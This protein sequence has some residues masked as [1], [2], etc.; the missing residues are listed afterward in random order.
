M[1]A[2]STELIAIRQGAGE[3]VE[4]CNAMFTQQHSPLPQPLDENNAGEL[5]D[6]P[7]C[8]TPGC[9][10]GPLC[11]GQVAI[12]LPEDFLERGRD[13]PGQLCVPPG[14]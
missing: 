8:L 14:R 5:P 2:R 7:C 6:A 10:P 12:R 3:W 11:P 1:L 4:E 13:G 9:N